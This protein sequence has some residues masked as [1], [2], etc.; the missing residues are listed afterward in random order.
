VPPESIDVAF[1]SQLIEHLHPEDVV[2]QLQAIY[3]ALVPGG[4][5]ICL[6]PHRFGGP[7]DVSRLFDEVATGFHLKEYTNREL[8]RLF[9]GTGFSRISA[10]RRIGRKHVRFPLLPI[11]WLE[12]LLQP[13]GHPQRRALYGKLRK[14]LVPRLISWK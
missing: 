8:A 13:L 12:A 9:R 2:I 1:S 6:T 7:A 14:I 10:L 11:L 4:V 5:Y 3:R